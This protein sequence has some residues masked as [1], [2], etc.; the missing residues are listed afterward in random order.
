MN[1]FFNPRRR[2]SDRLR[3]ELIRRFVIPVVGFCVM[4]AFWVLLAYC[5]LSVQ[6]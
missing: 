2:A 5:A 3:A 1:A 4:C 6:P